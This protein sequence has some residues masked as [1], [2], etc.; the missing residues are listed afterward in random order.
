M[1]YK[2]GVCLVPCNCVCK[3]GQAS[4]CSKTCQKEDWPV[5]KRSCPAVSVGGIGYK[6]RGLVANRSIAMGGVI[7]T[8][9]PLMV[10][11]FNASASHC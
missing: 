10:I 5:H 7:M 2:C 9:K 1:S 11:N 6:G 3:C 8:E 4:Y